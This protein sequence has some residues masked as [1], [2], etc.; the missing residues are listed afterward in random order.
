LLTVAVGD[1]LQFTGNGTRSQKNAGLVT[2]GFATV[3]GIES[4]DNKAWRMTVA[5]DAGKGAT[6]REV[7]FTVGDNWKAGEFDRF[8]LGYAGTIYKAQGATLDQAYVCHSPSLRNATS[9][10]GLTRHRTAVKMFASR[11]AIRRMD[12]TRTIFA[13]GKDVAPADLVRALDIMAAGMEREQNKR[14]ATSYYLDAM[15]LSVDFPSAAADTTTS[16]DAKEPVQAYP[17]SKFMQTERQQQERGKALQAL[18]LLLGREVS[19]GEGRD[20]SLDRGRGQQL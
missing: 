5:I 19:Q 17:M 13:R 10:V 12:R 6:P 18:S 2:A 15:S 16:K 4:V 1:R 7:T 11:E 8:K 9:Y 20:I 14:S 3:K